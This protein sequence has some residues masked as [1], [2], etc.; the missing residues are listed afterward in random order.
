MVY[1][2]SSAV[3][4]GSLPFD[5]YHNQPGKIVSIAKTGDTSHLFHLTMLIMTTF[6]LDQSFYRTVEKYHWS[7]LKR[8]FFLIYDRNLDRD[9]N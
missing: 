7:F 9:L 8:I 4:L 5:I 2:N 1:R 3:I 6:S